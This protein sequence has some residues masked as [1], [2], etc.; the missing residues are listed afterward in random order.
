MVRGYFGIGIE[1]AKSRKNVGN[2]FRSAMNFNADF[3]FTI[4]DRYGKQVRSDTT[5]VER[6][7]PLWPFVTIEDLKNHIPEDCPII[8]VEIVKEAKDIRTF[9]H[10][11]RAVYILG[12]EDIGLS[13][14]AQGICKEIIYIPSNLCLNV[15]VAGSIVMYDRFCKGKGQQHGSADKDAGQAE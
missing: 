13:E 4:G 2:L 5:K 10:P 6:H 7:I 9:V 14:K 11:E 12:A 3:I 15:A 1:N 8:G